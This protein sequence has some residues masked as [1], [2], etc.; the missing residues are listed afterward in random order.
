MKY[1]GLR[2]Y[3][4]ICKKFLV[5]FRKFEK[6]PYCPVRMFVS[7]VTHLLPFKKILTEKNFWHESPTPQKVAR[8]GVCFKKIFR[9]PDVQISKIWFLSDKTQNFRTFYREFWRNSK[10]SILFNIENCYFSDGN[11]KKRCF[12]A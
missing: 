5:R 9:I 4:T 1:N 8:S 11:R 3:T 7:R 10:K 6:H 12:L 2:G